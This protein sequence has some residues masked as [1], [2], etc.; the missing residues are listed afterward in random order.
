MGGGAA[1]AGPL[2]TSTGMIRDAG[3]VAAAV[4]PAAVSSGVGN[5]KGFREREGEGR[6][7][8]VSAAAAAPVPVQVMR[9][10]APPPPPSLGFDYQRRGGGYS[11]TPDAYTIDFSHDSY[12]ARSEDGED[13]G[14]G[15]EEAGAAAGRRGSR[16]GPLALAVS[17]FGTPAGGVGVD[18]AGGAGSS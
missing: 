13:V 1:A 10:P 5:S 4:P 12:Y 2:S 14:A 16:G 8:A 6:K 18:G 3:G 7:E 17:R 9:P 15:V 11:L